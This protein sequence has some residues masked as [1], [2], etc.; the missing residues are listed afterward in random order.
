M[1]TIRALTEAAA[2]NA[3]HFNQFAVPHSHE[4]PADNVEILAPREEFPP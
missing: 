1:P 2:E 4:G 3:P